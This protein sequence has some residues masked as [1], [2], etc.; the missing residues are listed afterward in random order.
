MKEPL[1]TR[2]LLTRTL[3][4]NNTSDPPKPTTACPVDER[5]SSPPI[6]TFPMKEVIPGLEVLPIV[7][8]DVAYEIMLL[9]GL[10]LKPELVKT[11]LGEG[12]VELTPTK[13]K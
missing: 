6:L 11:G 2:L 12:V 10:K 4:G 3:L 5:I 7:S 1:T 8:D 9:Y 13:V